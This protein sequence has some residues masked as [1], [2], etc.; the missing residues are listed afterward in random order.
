MRRLSRDTARRLRLPLAVALAVVASVV[1]MVSTT[2]AQY[3]SSAAA[4]TTLGTRAA[5]G[6]GTPYATLL[7]SASYLPSV[8]WR[9]SETTGTTTVADGSGHGRA[10][11]LTGSGVTFGTANTG[12]VTC[13]TTYAMRQLGNAGSTGRVVSTT[14]VTSPTTLTIA[15]WIRTTSLNGG[16]IVGFGDS[17]TA[18]ST[19]QDRALL[20][21]R[22]GRVVFQVATTTGN[23]LL[24]SP[25]VV[26]DNVLHLVV[27]TLSGT[28]AR[29]YVDGVQVAAGIVA[30]PRATYTGY[31]RAGWEQNITAIITG[32]R[33]QAA[34]RQDEVAIWEGRALSGA[35]VAA[36]WGANHW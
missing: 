9:F 24:T 5:C 3:T 17:A 29:L 23:V 12:L 32:S 35:E 10:G 36:L 6:G 7:G 8:W 18:G 16:R 25:A 26:S 14:P 33:N 2:S 30:A 28:S 20:L 19:I 21:D 27:A 15:T 11:T 13:D 34:L 22:T 31:W 4:T 1:P